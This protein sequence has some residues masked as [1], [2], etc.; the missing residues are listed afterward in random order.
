MFSRIKR[1]WLIQRVTRVRPQGQKGQSL[2]EMAIIA[3]LLLLLFIGV[4]EVGWA[5]RGY[6]VLVNADREATRFAARGR[7]LD[8]SQTDRNDVGYGTV[9]SHTLDSISQRLPFDVVSGDPNGTLIISHYLVDTGKPCQDPPCNDDCAADH[10]NKNGLCDCSSPERRE[11]DYPYDDMVLHP[12]MPGYQHFIAFYGIPR[13][14]RVNP[15][16]LVTQLKEENDAFNC[17]LNVQDPLAP[18]SINSVVVVE[19]FYDQPQLLGVPFISNHFTDPVPL[20]VH[21]MMRI[22]SD[23]RGEGTLSQGGGCALLPIAVHIDTLRGLNVGDPTG[24]IR[25]GAGSGDFGWLRW[26]DDTEAISSNPNSEEYLAEEINNPRLSMNDYREPIH[27]DP[28]DTVI[29]A[30]DWVWGLTGNVN[31]NG[32]ASEQLAARVNQGQIH[33]IP[34]W[35]VASD[36]GTNVTYHIVRFA[37]VTLEGFDLTGSP[38][39]IWGTFQ[40]WDDD[41]CKSNGH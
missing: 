11:P 25:N 14:S 22:S 8:F 21:T 6:I 34:V 24:N 9:L 17:T 16:E 3:P 40:G 4:L 38:K 26:T 2:V 12:G 28:D 35:D 15:D 32:V 39:E 7:Y 10:N 36:T 13:E 30:G 5:I 20:Y 1:K 31:S 41:A 29:N 23:A 27:K 18:W 19:S 33:R 37:L